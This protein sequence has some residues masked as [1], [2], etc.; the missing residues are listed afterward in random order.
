MKMYYSQW[1]P[2][3][4]TENFYVLFLNRF[5]QLMG[6]NKPSNGNDAII[7]KADDSFKKSVLNMVRKLHWDKRIGQKDPF[8]E[9]DA[10]EMLSKFLTVLK[11]IFSDLR[12]QQN[13]LVMNQE[14]TCCNC[15]KMILQ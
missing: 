13:F 15:N 1:E 4:T 10:L 5:C 14:I 8:F 6:W 11:D 3:L 2:G 9:E 7:V 12:E